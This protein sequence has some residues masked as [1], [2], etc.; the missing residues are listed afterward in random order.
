LGT[1]IPQQAL[2]LALKLQY[3]DLMALKSRS[4]PL[5]L[6]GVVAI[7]RIAFRS[8]ALYDLDSVNFAL[9]MRRFAPSVHQPHPP[10]YFLYICLGRLFSFFFRDANLSLVMLSVVSSCGLV[11]LIYQLAHEWFGENAARFAA[12]LFLLSPLAWFHG[13]VAL[14]YIV[15][16]FFS[17]LIGYLC[18]RTYSGD[19][20][21]ALP[22][23]IALGV[24]A[25]VRPSSLLFLTPLFLLSLHAATLRR[26]ASSFAA[27]ALTLAAWFIPM[28]RASGGL[29][30]YLQALTSLWRM[31]PAKETVF[32]SSPATSIVRAITIGFIYLL[33]FGAASLAPL[34]ATF[35][36]KPVDPRKKWF[37]LVW[38][39]PGLCFFTFGYLKFVNSGYLL[40]LFAPTCIWLGRWAAAWYEHTGW[41]RVLKRAV[42]A[43][44]AATN[45]LI[46]L[47]SPLYCSYRSVRHFEAE[48]ASIRTALPQFA[49]APDTLIVS[50]DSHFLGFRHAGYYN[51]EYV[52]LEYPALMQ[53]DGYRVFAMRGDDTQLAAELPTA[54]YTRFVLFPLPAGDDDYR[55]YMQSVEAKLPAQDLRIDTLGGHDYIS[56]PIADLPLLF[57]D[58]PPLPV[59]AAK[60]GVYDP[61]HSGIAPVN[62]RSH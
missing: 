26:I 3:V 29:K 33:C 34:G 12:T 25:G 53:A 7:T 40:L 9:G 45:V 41:N 2:Q 28:I 44:F 31:V 4:I 24:S 27:L 36:T 19:K 51:P 15:E 48:L 21:F 6:V 52:T 57:P 35:L 16:A 20:K 18:W 56:A 17:G 61:L 37:T 39:A 49:P 46:F 54:G 23:A 1:R 58:M 55:Q 11:I 50:M 30:A 59:D 60:S 5:L 62:S 32:S 43:G 14:T 42:I 10:G 47:A 22:A 8:H 38:I 13:I